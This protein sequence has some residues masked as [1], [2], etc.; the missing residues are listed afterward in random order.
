MDFVDLLFLA[1]P[2][3]APVIIQEDTLVDSPQTPTSPIEFAKILTAD[4]ASSVRTPSRSRSLEMTSVHSGDAMD[5][6]PE[7]PIDSRRMSIGSVSLSL[8]EEKTPEQLQRARAARITRHLGDDV[9][10]EIL[11]RAASPPPLRT[12]SSPLPSLYPLEPMTAPLDRTFPS[13]AISPV[14][15]TQTLPRRSAS[16][17]RKRGKEPVGRRLS[18][19]LKALHGTSTSLTGVVGPRPSTSS[20]KLEK[21]DKRTMKRTRSMWVRKVFPEGDKMENGIS[22][23][24]FESPIRESSDTSTPKDPM[25]ERDRIA[26]VKRA[27]KMTQVC[28]PHYVCFRY[29][30]MSMFTP[31][32]L[33]RSTSHCSLPDHQFL[34]RRLGRQQP[35]SAT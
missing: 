32:V 24:E 29:V 18:L 20:E 28:F 34:T 1:T 8:P 15:N 6:D 22:K 12:S 25:S 10:P 21:S 16:L 27:K 31:A 26:N 7:S 4:N 19:D 14:L 23:N 33:W 5:V 13:A 3:P 2:A 35:S 30:L 11:F 9:P 17:R